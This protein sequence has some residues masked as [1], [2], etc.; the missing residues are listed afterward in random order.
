MLSAYV[1]LMLCAFRKHKSQFCD[2]ENTHK[3]EVYC[4]LVF[5][6]FYYINIGSKTTSVALPGSDSASCD[7]SM[8]VPGCC[9]KICLSFDGS[10]Y[11]LHFYGYNTESCA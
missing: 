7:I 5:S 6:L 2:V 11:I 9:D 10:C 3:S 1:A 8:L 4:L